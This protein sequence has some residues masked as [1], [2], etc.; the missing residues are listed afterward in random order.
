MLSFVTL[1]KQNGKENLIT[2]TCEAASENLSLYTICFI[3]T[4]AKADNSPVHLNE[5]QLY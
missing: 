4:I 5:K 2:N 1:E 3:A